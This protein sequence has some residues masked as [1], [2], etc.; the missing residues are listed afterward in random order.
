MSLSATPEAILQ[1]WFGHADPTQAP[2]S[3]PAQ[4][5]NSTPELDQ[6]LR[7]DFGPL[8][9]QAGL[10]ALD[11]WRDSP[12]SALALVI[13]CDQFPRNIHRHTARAFAWDAR[14][15]SVAHHIHSQGWA[16]GWHLD[17]ATFSL[18]PFEHSEDLADQDLCVAAFERLVKESNPQD[19][20]NAKYYLSFAEEHR[21]LIA[22]FGRFP[23]RN[24]ALGRTSTEAER[25]H[26]ASGGKSFGQG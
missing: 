22:R 5:W 4:W 10:G 21:E 26:M 15:R 19:R 12:E 25:A 3:D 2:T 6:R 9:E 20:K 14:A 24:T 13:L 23:H 17:F 11:G 1:F 7:E 16:A 8:L 18:M